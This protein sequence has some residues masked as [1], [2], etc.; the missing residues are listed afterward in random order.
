[1][2]WKIPSSFGSQELYSKN[3]ESYIRQVYTKNVSD[4]C[5]IYINKMPTLIIN[6]YCTVMFANG[7][8]SGKNRLFCHLIDFS[9]PNRC[10]EREITLPECSILKIRIMDYD[11]FGKNELIGETSIDVESRYYSKYRATCGLPKKYDPYLIF[12]FKK[13][14][15]VNV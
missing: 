6:R 9:I 10:Y 11:R 15:S 7:F 4:E 2:V 5:I 3:V 8:K 12:F 1:M 14:L 13:K